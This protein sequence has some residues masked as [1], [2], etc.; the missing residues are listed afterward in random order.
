VDYDKTEIAKTY[1][2]ARGH[3]PDFLA[4]WM[5]TVG[6]HIDSSTIRTVLDVGCGTGRFSAALATQLN[7]SVIGVDPSIKMLSE[8]VRNGHAHVS[9]VCGSAES[10]PLQSDCADLIFISMAFH[11]FTNPET[12]AQ[13]CRRVLRP[14]GRVFLRT[15]CGERANAYPYVPYFPSTKAMIEA[16][17]PS[18]EFQ[19]EAFRAASFRVLYSGVVIQQVAVDYE[20]YADKLALRADSI[21]VSL[22][23]HEFNAGIAAVRSEKRPGPISEPIDVVVFEK[24]S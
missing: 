1:D 19:C 18:M 24:G 2:Q 22:D 17:L 3:G 12:A 10:I 11:H 21:L 23:D 16:R 20:A 8:A 6:A 14:N 7:A 4:L 5:E 15:G 9:H 13:E